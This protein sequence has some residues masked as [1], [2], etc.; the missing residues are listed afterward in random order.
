VGFLWKGHWHRSLG[1]FVTYDLCKDSQCYVA[2][3]CVIL[4]YHIM[5]RHISLF[6]SFRRMCHFYTIIL[7][8]NFSSTFFLSFIFFFCPN[9]VCDLKHYLCTYMQAFPQLWLGLQ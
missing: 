4:I 5:K 2:K 8:V 1:N 6:V 9:E 3:V 7:F